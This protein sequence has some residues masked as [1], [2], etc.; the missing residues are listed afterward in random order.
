MCRAMMLEAVSA[1]ENLTSA[2]ATTEKGKLLRG[3]NIL[4]KQTHI[5]FPFFPQAPQTLNGRSFPLEKLISPEVS[6]IGGVSIRN[7]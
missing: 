3:I 2:C 4:M 6:N 1:L 5:C 7:F